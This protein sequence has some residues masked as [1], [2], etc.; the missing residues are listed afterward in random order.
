MSRITATGIDWMTTGPDS[1]EWRGYRVHR[2]P[3]GGYY[4][5]APNAAAPFF[6]AHT[7]KDAKAV[8]EARHE[9]STNQ[10]TK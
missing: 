1:W 7:L 10:P 5:Y 3:M 4:T 6:E 2:E 8:C 9:Q